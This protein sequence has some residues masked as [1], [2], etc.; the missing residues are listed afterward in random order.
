M[1]RETQ[2]PHCEGSEKNFASI[3][4]ICDAVGTLKNTINRVHIFQELINIISTCHYSQRIL[5]MLPS[6]SPLAST[7]Q[8]TFLKIS[9]V[10]GELPATVERTNSVA[11]KVGEIVILDKQFRF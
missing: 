9:A 4:Y 2:N 7:S 8:M 5:C 3:F 6:R 10:N 11:H 1:Y